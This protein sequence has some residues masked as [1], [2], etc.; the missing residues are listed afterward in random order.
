MN[1][2]KALAVSAVAGMLMGSAV[3]CGGSSRAARFGPRGVG[4]RQVVLQRGR[5]R[6]GARRA[7]ASRPAAQA[8]A[9]LPSTDRVATNARRVPRGHA[10]R[11]SLTRPGP[12]ASASA[13]EFPTSASAWGFAARTSSRCC[14]SGR[15]W[16]GSRSSARTTSPRAGSSAPTSRRS[17]RGIPWCLTACRSPSAERTPSTRPTSRV[18]EALVER[19]LAPWCSDHL[20][21]T[22]SAGI[23]VHD[24]LPV[25]FTRATL[26]HV[27]ERVRRVQGE[28]GVP[29]ALENASSY[30]EFRESTIPEHEFLADARRAGRLR[31]APRR[32]QRLRERLQPWLR[33]PGV[34]RR[35][36]GRARGADPPGRPHGQAAPTCS[37]R[38]PTH[39]KAEVWE[40]Y[41]RALRR[42]GPVS[43]LVEWDEDIPA[44]DVLSTEAAKARAVRA[45]TLAS[46]AQE[47]QEGAW[48]AAISGDLQ[49]LVTDLVRGATPLPE[50]PD[51]A[52]GVDAIAL[53]GPRGMTPR[54][55]LE[56]YRA[57]VLVRGT[58]RAW[59]K[60]F[61]RSSRSSPASRP[62]TGSR[63]S[64]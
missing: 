21:W 12:W 41:R 11:S 42:C 22:G 33:C 46:P 25:P 3:A 36:P 19:V 62:S 18:C 16:T 10:W 32:E 2:A 50:R 30:V 45:E 5:R 55:R 63:P 8:A 54:E 44:W 40:L 34:H 35:D 51:L 20:C 52:A 1:I 59:R 58:W 47:G 29:L 28:L 38:T 9:R 23:D 61:R 57:T 39:V 48:P 64:T 6:C 24:L 31:P 37:T 49:R 4:R 7:A 53:P 60:T 26:D 13:I 56:V 14:A 17:A 27:V 43:T 15:P